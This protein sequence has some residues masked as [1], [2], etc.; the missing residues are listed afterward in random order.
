MSKAREI[1]LKMD[2][3]LNYV[4]GVSIS[5][6]IS[7]RVGYYA[8][9]ANITT[10]IYWNILQFIIDLTFYPFDNLG[11]CHQVHHADKSKGDYKPTE[12]I[13]FFF[14]L[15]LF[16]ASSCLIMIIPFYLAWIFGVI[17]QKKL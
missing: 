8:N 3:T 15:S 2:R 13:V 11:H 1:F 10:R 9:H 17:K 14:L 12:L 6:T 4:A 7:G 5:N 16:T